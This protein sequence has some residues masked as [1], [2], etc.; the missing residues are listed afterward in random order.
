MK[1]IFSNLKWLWPVL[2][3]LV[4]IVS[5]TFTNAYA[6][7]ENNSKAVLES[8]DQNWELGLVFYQTFGRTPPLRRA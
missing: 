7:N 8:T 3:I 1:K 6:N 4:A 5:P 2:L